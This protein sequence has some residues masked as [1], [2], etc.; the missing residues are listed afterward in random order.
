MLPIEH[1]YSAF[2]R[3][4]FLKRNEGPD[5]LMHCAIGIA[6]EAGELADCIKKVWVYGAALDRANLVEELGDLE[7]YMEALRGLAGITRLEVLEE[8]IK[9]LTKRYPQEYTDELALRRLDKAA[10]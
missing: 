5:G 6:G 7:W 1:A 2:V 8:N 3:R 10:E 9:K 4:R